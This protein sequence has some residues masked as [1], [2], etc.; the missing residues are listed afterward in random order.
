VYVSNSTGPKESCPDAHTS[1]ALTTDQT[2]HELKLQKWFSR[3]SIISKREAL[4]YD[5]IVL[6]N[7]KEFLAPESQTLQTFSRQQ[8]PR[9]FFFLNI[10]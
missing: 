3:Y 8:N 6:D 10:R 9:T 7:L 4:P 2:N 5:A 1:T